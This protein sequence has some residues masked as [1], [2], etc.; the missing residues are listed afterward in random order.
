[1]QRLG[2]PA[3]LWWFVITAIAFALQAF[4]FTG[5][6][7]M[8]AMAP[9]WSVLTINAGFSSL[10]IQAL[11]GRIDRRW[12]IAPVAWFTGYAALASWSHVAVWQLT[13]TFTQANATQHIAFDGH[14]QT[15]VFPSRSSNLQNAASELIE[16]YDL[17]V[18]YQERSNGKAESYL[19]YRLAPEDVCNS[20]RHNKSYEDAGV[21][22][23][24]IYNRPFGS[25]RGAVNGVCTLLMPEEPQFEP[26]F[27]S[28]QSKDTGDFILPYR[29]VTTT[30]EEGNHR[31]TLFSGRANPLS[32][33]PMPII[34][35]F[36]LDSPS[37]WNCVFQFWRSS[38][39]IPRPDGT[40]SASASIV[41][42]ALGL[43]YAP[44]GE[45]IDAINAASMPD[46]RNAVKDSIQRATTTVDSVIANPAQRITIFDVRGLD[47][48]P[49]IIAPR[50]EKIGEAVRG[51]LDG[52]FYETAN[53]LEDLLAI[54]P[55]D[56]FDPVARTLLEDLKQR[57]K[58]NYYMAS[59]MF[60]ARL[61]DFGVDA[62]PVLQHLAFEVDAVRRRAAL[63]GLCRS[64]PVA[65]PFADRI[66]QI[67]RT[68]PRGDD[69]HEPAFV[70]LLRIGRRDLA[71]RDPH[72]DS[73]YHRSNYDK[74]LATV[75]PVSPVS[76][77]DTF[78]LFP[79]NRNT[80]G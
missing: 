4:P 54:L 32:W 10:A 29:L 45:R 39:E 2:L 71:L 73:N 56:Q 20:V 53:I 64:G 76:V 41:A 79:Q 17:P 70:A 11:T 6:F 47:A 35:C 22:A 27:V 40:S 72:A 69:S 50:A 58:V 61:G 36:L 15:V 38:V 26:A 68:T 1:M 12:L 30:V 66:N 48:R 16:N 3:S 78:W 34:G 18:A 13:T 44:A 55:S 74:W 62:I 75:S 65:A 59:E 8:F 23:W 43:K 80:K 52:G 46:V 31:I 7:L 77:C 21:R 19:S 57:P 25:R 37:S 42:A 63:V 51:A 14:N 5:I 49:D 60:V 67:L 28:D 24:P 33:L 9:F